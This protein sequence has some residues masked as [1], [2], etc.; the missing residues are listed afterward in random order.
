MGDSNSPTR[1]RTVASTP[2]DVAMPLSGK[3]CEETPDDIADG[4]AN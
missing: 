2:V 4:A 1:T 3:Y